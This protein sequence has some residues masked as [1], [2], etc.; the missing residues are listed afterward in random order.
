M[1][2]FKN[3]SLY[4]KSKEMETPKSKIVLDLSH[5]ES[6]EINEMR[7]AEKGRRENTS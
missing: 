5:F 1:I 6:F 2:K 3:Q 4:L 7:K